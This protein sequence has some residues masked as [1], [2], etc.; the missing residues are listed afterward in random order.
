MERI[1]KQQKKGNEL[2]GD[3]EGIRKLTVQQV[4][5]EGNENTYVLFE[6][7]GKWNED[8]GQVLDP[9]LDL[10]DIRNQLPKFS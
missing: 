4:K 2:R 7:Y 10:Y 8:K 3:E 1:G 5:K 6:N 9:E